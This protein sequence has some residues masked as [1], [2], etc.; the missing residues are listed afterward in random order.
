MI[1]SPF[2]YLALYDP[3]VEPQG[4][5]RAYE[6]CEKEDHDRHSDLRNHLTL[7]VMR[8]CGLVSGLFERM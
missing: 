4:Q 5:Y 7:S 1:T 2:R 8:A 6:G 3:D